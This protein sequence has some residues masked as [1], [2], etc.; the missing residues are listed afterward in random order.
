MVYLINVS[1]I[2]YM[3]MI[4][5]ILRILSIVAPGLAKRI[6]LKLGERSTMTQNPKFKYEDWGPTF[7]TLTFVKTVL[8]HIWLSLGD[9]A[10]VGKTAPDTPLVTLDGTKRRLHDFF[11]G[12][13]SGKLNS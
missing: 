12:I 6:V 10:F 1:L 7:A 3:L 8:G 2:F 11:K 4:T 13:S 5:L 9:E